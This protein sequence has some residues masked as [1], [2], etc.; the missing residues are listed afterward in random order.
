[1]KQ[2]F[3]TSVFLF[4]L[5]VILFFP[6][7]LNLFPWQKQI[8]QTL[9]TG[10]TYF[11]ANLFDYPL[12]HCDFSSDSASMYFLF[13]VLGML[14][15][16]FATA[17]H[18]N[19]K[20]FEQRLKLFSLI[21]TI[22]TYYLAIILLNYGFNKI[23]KWQFY[24]PEP[25][26]L[27]TRVGQLGKDMLYWTSMGTSWWYSF[28][29]GIIEI[30]PAILILFR[31]TRVLGLLISMAVLINVFAIN[32]GFDI[33]VKLFSLFLIFVVVSLL[34]PNLTA[35]YDF[36]VRQKKT[37]LQQ[38]SPFILFKSERLHKTIKPFLI[39][40]CLIETSY[41]YLVTMNVND[42]HAPRNY[43]HG[44]YEPYRGNHLY[45]YPGI[46]GTVS[47]KRFYIHRHGYLVLETYDGKMRDFHL[48]I[49]STRNTFYCSGYDGKKFTL[50]YYYEPADSTLTLSSNSDSK[51]IVESKAIN[52]RKLPAIRHQFHWV[53]DE[54]GK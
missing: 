50:A 33:S 49:D 52:W 47:I 18:V 36:L 2:Y 35:L 11:T 8:T 43:L 24:M 40:F 20:L 31:K 27:Y 16:T 46:H 4:I 48:Q 7:E 5:L 1:M 9:F 13:L 10:L 17:F 34:Q 15:L 28:F 54:Y 39:A 29:A 19:A 6:V 45:L 37:S 23:F 32:I 44:A 22:A 25:N 30:I 38:E 51:S 53:V 41:P 12:L 42:D 21:R 14:A 3:K 26:T